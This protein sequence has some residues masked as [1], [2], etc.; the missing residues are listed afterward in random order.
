M[1]ALLYVLVPQNLIMGQ[2]KDEATM[3]IVGTW[4]VVDSLDVHTTSCF[5]GTPPD[6]HPINEVVHYSRSAVTIDGRRFRVRRYALDRVSIDDF[7]GMFGFEP[8]R[9]PVKAHNAQVINVELEDKNAKG[10]ETASIIIKDK[11]EIVLNWYC[12]YFIARRAN[13]V[14]R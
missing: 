9:I 10:L 8:S 7:V 1:V 3:Q 4:K 2:A 14:P 13:L 11:N 6:L 5:E 12:T